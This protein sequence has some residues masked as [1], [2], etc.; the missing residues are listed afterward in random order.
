MIYDTK[1]QYKD[2]VQSKGFVILYAVVISSLVLAVGISIISIATKQLKISGLG[3]QSQ[4]AFYAANTGTECA[5]FWDLHGYLVDIGS[6]ISNRVAVFPSPLTNGCLGTH[7]CSVSEVPLG[8]ESPTPTGQFEVV[9]SGTEI[10]FNDPGDP[11]DGKWESIASNVVPPAIGAKN[12]T[13]FTVRLDPTDAT[14]ASSCARVTVT[15]ELTGL[16]E[17]RTTIDSRGY[18]TCDDTNPRQVERGLRYT[19]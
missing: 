7:P 16:T 6:G 14:L 11:L 18:N 2:P 19:Y 8:S 5:L 9:C 10:M 15:K 17:V 13:R 12:T 4:Y 1:N 3:S